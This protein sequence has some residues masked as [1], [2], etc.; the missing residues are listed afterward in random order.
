[1]NFLSPFLSSL[2]ANLNSF[3]PRSQN[4]GEQEQQPFLDPVNFWLRELSLVHEAEC[5]IMLQSKPVSPNNNNNN[6]E[7]HSMTLPK[8]PQQ[9]HQVAPP[10][11]SL[12]DSGGGGSF[13]AGNSKDTIRAIQTRAHSISAAFAKLCR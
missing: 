4:G 2:P 5:T 7:N 12:D 1:M 6:N 9:Q 8:T 13:W 11:S 10:L 3:Q